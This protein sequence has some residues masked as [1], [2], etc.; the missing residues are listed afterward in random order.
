MAN[1]GSGK[2]VFGT[3]EWAAHSVNCCTGCSHD[4]RYCYAKGMAVRFG[5]CRPEE[6][7]RERV[8]HAEVVR[9]RRKLSGSVMFPTTHDITP[10]NLDACLEV[11]GKLLAAGNRVLIVSKP[12][13]ACV[14][15]LVS[16]CRPHRQQVL[17]RFTMGATNY[18]VLHYWEP[19]APGFAER[20]W[21][22]A[23][24]RKAG[25]ATS[26]SIEPM[27][28]PEHVDDVIR[29]ALSLCTDSVW[30]GKMNHIGRYTEKGG[31]AASLAEAQ[32]DAAIL[33]IY[34]RWRAEPKVRW[35]ESI[36]KVVGI[37]VPTEAGMDI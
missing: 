32:N 23:C 17:F 18:S 13:R 20:M 11:L 6:W 34:K 7:R 3:R 5:R 2:G 19:G 33:D 28:D 8:R 16:R 26:V 10:H 25:F 22:L 27:L 24:A 14:E 9:R 31:V 30:V 37:H 36:K 1:L 21:C 15:A 35:K 4:C 29:P 12:H